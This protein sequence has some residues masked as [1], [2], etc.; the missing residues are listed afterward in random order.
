MADSSN[1]FSL[2]GLNR[3]KKVSGL[4]ARSP[5][6]ID[7]YFDRVS[8]NLP[9]MY[10]RILGTNIL[11]YGNDQYAYN[12]KAVFPQPEHPNGIRAKGYVQ[13]ELT[14]NS[15]TI[16]NPGS[17]FN[18][19]EIFDILS[20]DNNFV[21][22]FTVTSINNTGGITDFSII[23]IENDYL[24]TPT[25]S[26]NFEN[27]T[28]PAVSFNTNR[29][30]LNRIILS[31][32]GHGYQTFDTNNKQQ[33]K[34]HSVTLANTGNGSGHN[35]VT[36]HQPLVITEYEDYRKQLNYKN[37]YGLVKAEKRQLSQMH[38]ILNDTLQQPN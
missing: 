11:N 27:N 29:F 9:P 13:L 32:F 36:T 16:T 4:Y 8:L 17:G 1:K 7:D 3:Q 15:F 35:I 12:T 26:I 19:G 14:K 28:T 38:V 34:V 21:A 24:M 25:Y 10:V 31:N 5:E 20:S 18:V 2:N 30:R 23:H 22:W 6:H 33:P 37:Q